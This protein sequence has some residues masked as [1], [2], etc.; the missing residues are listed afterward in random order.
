MSS[1]E[2]LVQPPTCG[3]KSYKLEGDLSSLPM[4]IYPPGTNTRGD[5]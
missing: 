5:H 1:N 3:G 2:I 4:I